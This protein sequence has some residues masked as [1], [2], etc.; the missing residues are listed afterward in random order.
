MVGEEAAVITRAIA[1]GSL[2]AVA[3]KPRRAHLV[4]IAGSGMS[5]LAR[6][7][8]DWG[9]TLSGSDC[10]LAGAADL[11]TRGVD[12]HE[13]HSRRYLPDEVDLVVRSDAIEADN[14]ELSIAAAR[15]IP[16]HSYFEMLASLGLG[17]RTL[18]V[19]GTHGKSTTTAMAAEIFV[20][21]GLDPTAIYGATPIGRQSGARAG[22]SRWMLVEACEYRANFLKLRPETAVVLGIEPDHL[23]YY[24]SRE[25]LQ[26]AFAR[27]VALAP[28]GG[29]VLARH[30]CAATRAVTAHAVAR[31]ETFGLDPGAAWVAGNLRGCAG[32]YAFELV[33]HGKCLGTI[34]LQVP[35]RHQVLNA[36]AAAALALEHQAAMADVVAALE[37]FRGLRRRLEVRGVWRGVDL[38]DDYAHHPTEVAATLTT[39]REM[40]PQRRVWCVFQPHQASRT[41]YFLDE[42]A[43]ALQNT[44]KLIVAEIFRAREPPPRPGE[45]TAAL[46]AAKAAA[47]GVEVLGEHEAQAIVGRLRER[48]T[49]GDVLVT[50]G[51]GDIGKIHSHFDPRGFR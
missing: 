40:Y 44:D 47:R 1:D 9:W 48:L 12:L 29:L 49:A 27:F 10:A 16:V 7:L 6:L 41:A 8:L 32:R 20:R 19:A 18:A 30:E 23:D 24:G 5:S 17:R 14:P 13:G 45:V 51:A 50:I 31:V 4:G 42:F 35:G 11:A 3:G 25:A 46:L 26:A 15:G 39:I 34:R 38:L 37:A 21:A 43:T 33:R 36:L 2:A 22:G 28:A